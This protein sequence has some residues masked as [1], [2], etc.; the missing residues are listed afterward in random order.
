LK[1]ISGSVGTSWTGRT[2]DEDPR[3]NYDEITLALSSFKVVEETDLDKEKLCEWSQ[4]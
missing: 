3:Y 4:L 1:G 2:T